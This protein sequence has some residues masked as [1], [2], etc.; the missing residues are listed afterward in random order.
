[1]EGSRTSRVLWTLFFALLTG[2]TLALFTLIE[3]MIKY[4]FSLAALFLAVKYFKRGDTLGY[5]IFYIVFAL[6]VFFVFITV[7]VTYTYMK[8][9]YNI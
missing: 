8:E 3:G 1:M 4:L 2:L 9:N 6:I 7:M 5:R